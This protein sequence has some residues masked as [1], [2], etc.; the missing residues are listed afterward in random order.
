MKAKEKQLALFNDKKSDI[1]YDPMDEEM[2]DILRYINE[3]NL[4]FMNFLVVLL[5]KVPLYILPRVK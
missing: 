5:L 4:I 2:L 1:S 3:R